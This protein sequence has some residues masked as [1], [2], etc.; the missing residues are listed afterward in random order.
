MSSTPPRHTASSSSSDIEESESDDNN[1]NNN[2]HNNNAGGAQYIFQEGSPQQ[3]SSAIPITQITSPHSPSMNP[4]PFQY[5]IIKD[6][7]TDAFLTLNETYEDPGTVDDIIPHPNRDAFGKVFYNIANENS[8]VKEITNN[9]RISIIASRVFD[10]MSHFGLDGLNDDTPP[11]NINEPLPSSC[12]TFCGLYNLLS[13]DDKLRSMGI[14]GGGDG[15]GDDD[16]GGDFNDDDSDVEEDDD[17]DFEDKDTSDAAAVV[18]G[19]R[20]Q[21][22]NKAMEGNHL[23]KIIHTV[24]TFKVF[25]EF[26]LEAT[27]TSLHAA[28]VEV[29]TFPQAIKNK[30]SEVRLTIIHY[31]IASVT[32][33]ESHL[34][35]FLYQPFGVCHV[36]N[37]HQFLIHKRDTLRKEHKSIKEELKKCLAT[38]HDLKNQKPAAVSHTKQPTSSKTGTTTKPNTGV[39]PS[40]PVNVINDPNLLLNTNTPILPDALLRLR[41]QNEQSVLSNIPQAA[42]NSQDIQNFVEKSYVLMA[43]GKANQK[44]E[45]RPMLT[46]S[47][48]QLML[49]SF[50]SASDRFCRERSEDPTF[51]PTYDKLSAFFVRSNVLRENPKPTDFFRHDD[52]DVYGKTDM[53]S[54][55]E[56]QFVRNFTCLS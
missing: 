4:D 2:N 44:I 21:L 32:V 51:R 47:G 10:L 39:P 33:I 22:K 7:V 54:L 5:Q 15:G 20:K 37:L 48:E 53:I 52:Y 14:M 49:Q 46:N 50:V 34:L 43:K 30:I 28:Q 11:A 3:P 29:R 31:V 40:Y 23:L 13:N 35:L 24:L 16:G 45:R 18:K 9:V 36:K 55:L 26:T 19:V 56:C 17:G 25:L 38:L 6:A 1:N 41:N 12:R 27:R 42:S 8:I